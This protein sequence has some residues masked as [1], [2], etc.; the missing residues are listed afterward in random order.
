VASVCLVAGLDRAGVRPIDYD[1]SQDQKKPGAL[2]DNEREQLKA[3]LR[4]AIE[5]RTG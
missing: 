5:G 2:T 4:K 3:L 1:P